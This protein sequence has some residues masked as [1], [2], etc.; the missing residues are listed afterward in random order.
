LQ[1]RKI[2]AITPVTDDDKLS[3]PSRKK[4]RET[5]EPPYITDGLSAP[6]SPVLMKSLEDIGTGA[7][8]EQ[9]K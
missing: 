8:S 5:P 3:E 9:G 4:A 2:S 1:K 7:C 6:Y